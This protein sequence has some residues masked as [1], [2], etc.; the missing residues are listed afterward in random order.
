MARDPMTEPHHLVLEQVGAVV[1]VMARVLGLLWMRNPLA[2]VHHSEQ[3]GLIPACTILSGR[4]QPESSKS[5][6]ALPAAQPALH[7]RTRFLTT[8]SE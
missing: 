8:V 1:M 5:G 4:Q 2:V 6:D 3:R 7:L